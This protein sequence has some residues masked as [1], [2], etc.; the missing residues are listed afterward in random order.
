MIKQAARLFSGLSAN[1]M[2]FNVYSHILLED[3][4]D[5]YTF[6]C[7][8][9]SLVTL[10]RI[11]GVM[12][13]P[14]RAEVEK[15]ESALHNLLK[16]NL[17]EKKEHSVSICFANDPT[18]TERVVR[19]S[20]QP[21][22]SAAKA[23]NLDFDDIIEE[24]IHT[25]ISENNCV[26][27]EN[28]IVLWSHPAIIPKD[29]LKEVRTKIGKFRNQTKVAF[30]DTRNPFLLIDGLTHRHNAFIEQTVADLK[31]ALLVV[32]KVERHEFVNITRRWIDT[33]APL[34]W[35]PSLH[36]DPMYEYE[37]H[38]SMPSHDHSNL[39]WPRIDSQIGKSPIEATEK[40]YIVSV[41]STYYGH[42]TMQL[43]PHEIKRFNV[44]FNRIP[45]DIP[46]R[47]T[48]HLTGA[49]GFSLIFQ[50]L[51]RYLTS[52]L[53]PE[54]KAI[55]NDLEKIAEDETGAGDKRKHRTRL[56]VHFTTWGDTIPEV[57]RSLSMMVQAIEGWGSASVQMDSLA[58]DET[59]IAGAP[60]AG[61]HSLSAAP[62]ARTEELV[63][64]MPLSRPASPWKEGSLLF[65]TTDRKLYPF[66]PGSSLQ[67]NHIFLMFAKPGQG[68]SVLANAIKTALILKGGI[69][70]L[71]DISTIDIGKSAAGQVKMI[72][73]RLPESRKY[74]AIYHRLRMI[75]EDAINVMDLELGM[76]EPLGPH[77]DTIKEILSML[78]TSSPNEE[79]NPEL[80][81]MFSL[82]IEKTYRFY[83]DKHEGGEPKRYRV[84]IYKDVDEQLGKLVKNERITI[85]SG[86]T[87]YEVVDY[88]FDSGRPELAILAQRQAV[89]TLENMI[90]VVTNDN[91]INSQYG[92]KSNLSMGGGS[93]EP[94]AVAFCRILGAALRDFPIMRKPTRLDFTRAKIK[95]LDIQ[96][97]APQGSEQAARQTGLMYLLALHATCAH[98]FLDIVYLDQFPEKYREY[99]RKRIKDIRNMP[100]RVDCDELHR[101]PATIVKTLERIIREGRKNKFQVGLISQNLGDFSQTMISQSTVRFILGQP[102]A[103]ELE[104]IVKAFNLSETDRKV[105]S[106]N[107]V[108]SP[109]SDVGSAFLMSFSTKMGNY[110]QV[111][112]MK[113]GP[114]ELWSYST[115]TEDN[116][117]TDAVIDILGP[118][119]GLDALVHSYPKA[120]IVPEFELRSRST[121]NQDEFIEESETKNI[122]DTIADEIVHR[123][124]DKLRKEG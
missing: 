27:E 62:Y 78:L 40:S 31:R 95:A 82:V 76:R 45:R 116:T 88:L 5:E 83:S 43:Y 49:P 17:N 59:L 55:V 52:K 4:I 30:S 18:G 36:G 22:F 113:K 70:T 98:Y 39:L 29:E 121:T 99:H 12:S 94:V 110:S 69:S 124:Q 53:N 11:D 2:K 24:N 48:S 93:G 34:D 109:Q 46:W 42:A 41:N 61:Y 86:T 6:V 47:M 108:H 123:Y 96:D 120:T 107:I 112:R 23:I 91:T 77:V 7:K 119:D 33:K 8:D 73:D 81:R 105:L 66:M 50:N 111:V 28:Y 65:T 67:D 15:A 21:A 85:E 87:W 122:L 58:P 79:L 68:K 38:E 114:R 89:P 101:A 54:N 72:K 84:G 3:D 19:N 115:T 102:E 14:G 74:E 16:A 106:S 56:Q 117:V 118:R 100:K 60:G 64:M 63:R 103:D 32:E 26:Y 51:I 1:M 80:A 37:K 57:E 71:P 25:A 10:L 13:I 92:E 35:T 75:D 97:V 9:Q 104:K 20:M 90:L 44:L